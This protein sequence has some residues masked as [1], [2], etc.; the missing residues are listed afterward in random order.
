MRTP[1]KLYREDEKTLAPVI[2]IGNSFRT[3]GIIY[4]P[5]TFEPLR[6]NSFIMTFPPEFNIPNNIVKNVTRPSCNFDGGPQFI[7]P[8]W[9]WDDI[10]VTFYDPVHPSIQ[11]RLYS[12]ITNTNLNTRNDYEFKIEILDTTG[13]V[14]SSWVVY[15]Y[16]NRIDNGLLD[17]ENDSLTETKMVITVNRVLTTL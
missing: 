17:Y 14:V 2:N 4:N 12:I 3:H 9:H 15:G 13:I 5:N 7:N 11:E 1:F 16:I 8:R 6:R 10:T